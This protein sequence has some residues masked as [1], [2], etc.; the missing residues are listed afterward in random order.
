MAVTARTGGGAL[1]SAQVAEMERW[2]RA[3]AANGGDE[4]LREGALAVVKLAREAERR[5]QEE[6]PDGW[7]GRWNH[8]W[9]SGSA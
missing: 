6:D 1:T 4:S 9:P 8:E 7:D 3:L 5:R 2:A